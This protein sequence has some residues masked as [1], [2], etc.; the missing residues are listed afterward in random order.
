MLCFLGP[1]TF[2]EAEKLLLTIRI[3]VILILVAILFS[4]VS[5]LSI[6]LHVLCSLLVAFLHIFMLQLYNRVRRLEPTGRVE[7]FG[8]LFF[9]CLS[10]ECL[11][12]GHILY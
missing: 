4:H 7:I 6:L 8:L 10:L 2:A 9:L 1:L 5:T 11:C 3:L 12:F